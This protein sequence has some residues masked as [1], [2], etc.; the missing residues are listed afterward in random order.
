MLV[1]DENVITCAHVVARALR[2]ADETPEMPSGSLILDFPYLKR[3]CEGHVIHWSPPLIDEHSGEVG[4]VAVVRLDSKTQEAQPTSLSP[5]RPLPGHQFRAV[6]YPKGYENYGASADGVIKDILPSGRMQIESLTVNGVPVQEGFSGTPVWDEELKGMVGM[7]VGALKGDRVGF[8]IPAQ[9]LRRIWPELPL[10][11]PPG[12]SEIPQLPE[13]FVNRPLDLA[14]MKETLL[15]EINQPAGYHKMAV[16]GMGGSGKSILAAALLLRDQE[17]WQFFPDGIFWIRLGKDAGPKLLQRQLGLAQSLGDKKGFQ[18]MEKGRERLRELLGER[19]VLIV[20]DDLWESNHFQPF[21][22]LGPDCRMMVTTR[23]LALL[24]ELDFEEQNVHKLG[25]LDPAQSGEMLANYAG[26]RPDAT[27]ESEVL[28][29][30]GRLPLALAMIGG[31]IKSDDR[32]QWNDVLEMLRN[33][34]LE[35]IKKRFKDYPY[36]DLLKAIQV[37]VMALEPEEQALYAD[38]A[39]FP[40]DTPIPE[41]VLEVFWK[42]RGLPDYKIRRKLARFLDLSLATSDGKGGIVL[43]DLLYDYVRRQA[44]DLEALHRSLLEAYA[45]VCPDGWHTG[46]DDSYFYQ[47]LAYHLLHSG[48]K[49]EL[50]RLLLDYRWLLARLEKTDVTSLISDYDLLPEDEELGLLQHCLRLSSHVLFRDSKELSGQLLGRMQ[51]MDLP[52]IRDLMQ[53]AGA[54]EGHSWLRPITS[55]LIAPGGPLIR[56][57]I[58]HAGGINAVALTSDGCRAVSASNDQTLKVWDIESGKLI[59]TLEGHAAGVNSVALTSDGRRAVS[60]SN[61]Q[62]LKVWDIESGKLLRTLEG[63]A[64]WVNAVALTSDGCRAVS[65]SDDKTLKVWDIES[66]KLIGTLEGHAAGVNA[67]ALTSDGCRAVSASNDKTLKVWDIESGKL[68]RTLEGHADWVNAVAL[69][70]D[71]CRAVSAS[72]DKTLKVWD[73]ESGKLLRT[74]EGHADWVNAVALTSD[75]CRAVSASND[76]TLKVWDIESGKLLRTLEGHAS[77]VR[78]VALTSDGRRAV[79]A[80]NDQTLKVWDIESGKLLRTLEGHADWVRAVAL[81]SDD[82]RAVSASSDQTLKVWDIE[83]GKLLRTLEGH[84]G[85]VNAVALTADGGRAVSASN[86][87][88][89]KVWDIESGELIGTL[90]GHAGWVNAVAL[91]AD[92]G[93]AV[94]ASDDQTLKVWDIESGKLLR[95]LEGHADWVNA[96]AL[97]ADGGRAVSASDDKTLKVWDIESGKLLR[98]LEGHAGGVNAVALTSDGRRAVSASDDQTLK[99]WDIESGKLLRTLEGHANWVRAV[100]LTPDDQRAVSASSDQTLKVWDIESGKLLRTLEGHADWVNSVALTSDG[101]RAVSASYDQTLKVWDLESGL[102][103]AS[104]AGESFMLSCAVSPDG[105]TIVAG[106]A[107]G[108]VHFLRLEGLPAS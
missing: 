31:M 54:G 42:Y 72:D 38:F 10:S 83:S 89:L 104:F 40:E 17:L 47:H 100:A 93:R 67:V 29:E 90:E 26:Q 98:T 50:K 41:A 49:E 63:H 75:G 7:V 74:L 68:L 4:D 79:S 95:T 71:G 107:S 81:T 60:A 18:D 80:S 37:S 78:A 102:M 62:T 8:I 64:D 48:R 11:P 2:I 56:S 66:G 33:A 3:S 91:T 14:G 84:A 46:P 15:K 88:T 39:V 51:G 1:D 24:K 57:L 69:T 77:W 21:D 73:I 20:L 35:E 96:V 30:C 13:Q 28:K 45:K 65:A 82:Q 19:R 16:Q 103:I 86:D 106:D 27:V 101:R 53:Q 43:H 92:G 85:G 34:D 32:L 59:G 44:S 23:D 99:V 70:S 94:S 55:S 108:R 52:G 9:E 105:R 25:L 5:A 6:G 61:D 36:P 97:T 12:L 22:C 87:Q 58:G 76:Q